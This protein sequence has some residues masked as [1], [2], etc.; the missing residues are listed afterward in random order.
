MTNLEQSQA[1]LALRAR[2]DER[3]EAEAA[4]HAKAELARI[5]MKRA[6]DAG[7]PVAMVARAA[8]VTR[9]RVWQVMQR[10]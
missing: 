7:V 4:F 8:R 10:E 1:L 2:V 6:L 3:D 9:G 5:A